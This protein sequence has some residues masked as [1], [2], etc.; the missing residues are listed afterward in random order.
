MTPTNAPRTRS[1]IQCRRRYS[2]LAVGSAAAVYSTGGTHP[3]RPGQRRFI[4]LDTTAATAKLADAWMEGNERYSN[5]LKPWKA[6]KFVG[7]SGVTRSE[8][9]RVGKECRCRW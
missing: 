8:E 5:C 3:M 7:S 4:S 2:R 6:S 9:R 1:L